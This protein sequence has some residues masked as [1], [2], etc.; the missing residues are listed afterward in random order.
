[1]AVAGMPEPQPHHAD[2]VAQMAIEMLQVI[3]QLDIAGGYQPRL[4]IGI[5]TGPVVAGV[6]GT[7]KFIYDLWGDT[8]NVASRM[9][10]L[11]EP[12]RIQ[13]T[14]G[15]YQRLNR[16]FAFEARGLIEVKGK[17]PTL[18]YWLVGNREP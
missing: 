9:E 10:S 15:T 14:E 7:K 17:G 2:M 1:M 18:T 3:D 5:N 13:V 11:G 8:V 16:R 4:R 6:I 12:N